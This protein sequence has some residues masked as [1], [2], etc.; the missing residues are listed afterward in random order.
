MNDFS[1]FLE[2]ARKLLQDDSF[3]FIANEI[4]GSQ[5]PDHRKLVHTEAAAIKSR[6]SDFHTSISHCN[7][8]GIIAWSRHPVGV[9]IEL[10][11]RVLGRLVERVSSSQDVAAAPSFAALWSAKEACFKALKAFDQPSVLSQI[12]IGE[13]RNIDSQTETYRLMNPRRFRSPSE[14]QGVVFQTV[15]HTCSFFV[16]RS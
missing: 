3:N 10:S 5:N 12:S 11:A 8:I 4:W 15:H 1:L 16:F 13:W 2:S 6:S 9:D 14:N 7:G